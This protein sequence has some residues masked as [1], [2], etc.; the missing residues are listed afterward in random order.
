MIEEPLLNIEYSAEV[1]EVFSRR[2]A[3]HAKKNNGFFAHSA[4]EILNILFIPG[5][6]R[7]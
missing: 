2:D 7:P 1:V 5:S 4:R 6:S 3:E